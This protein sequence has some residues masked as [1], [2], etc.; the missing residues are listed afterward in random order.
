MNCSKWIKVYYESLFLNPEYK[1]NRIFNEWKL[2][3]PDNIFEK[4]KKASS[5]TKEPTFIRSVESRHSKWK[6][7][8]TVDQIDGMLGV[9]DC[10]KIKDYSIDIYLVQMLH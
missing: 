10:V 6:T 8:L 7:N 3:I 1:I 5:T 2:E 4:V 9:L